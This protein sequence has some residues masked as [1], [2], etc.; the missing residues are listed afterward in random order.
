MP[1]YKVAHV[2]EQGTD[3]IIVP[4]EKRFGDKLASEQNAVVMGLQ[5]H[6]NA[7]G[8]AGT[9]VPVWET[10]NGGMGFLAPREWHPFFRSLSL[11]GVA[12]NLNKEVSW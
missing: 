3:L 8:L 6:A 11:R 1:R 5:M 2:R 10:R 9:V 4:L 12:A 7:A